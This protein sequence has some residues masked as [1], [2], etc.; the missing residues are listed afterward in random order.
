[1][2]N[3]TH[4]TLAH[5]NTFSAGLL[6]KINVGLLMDIA[7]FTNQTYKQTDQNMYPLHLKW[8]CS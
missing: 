8:A 5:T 3:D 1:M 2:S 4:S 6:K 7:S